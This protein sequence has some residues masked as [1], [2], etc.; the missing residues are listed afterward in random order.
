MDFISHVAD[1]YPDLTRDFADD[2]INLLTQHHAELESELREK[3]VG[4]LVLLRK[5]ELIDSA[6]YVVSS[7]VQSTES[8]IYRLLNTLFPIL[9]VTP[10]K[11]LRTFLYAKIISDLRSSNAKST[12]HKLNR[13][14]QNV[15]FN[16]LTSDRTSPKGIWAIRVTRELWRRQIWSDAK[17]VEIMK[18]AALSEDT[19][20]IIGGVSFFLG[21]DK[22]REEAAD[23]SSDEDDNL[24]MG[25]LK[26]VAGVNKK[27]VKRARDLKAA[28]A[29]VRRKERKK[30]QPH[31]LNFSA[32]HLLNDPQG[33]AE[34]LFSRHLQNK[35]SKLN[36]EQKLAVLQLVTRLVGL[37]KLTIES[38]YSW[39]TDKLNPRQAS[40]TSF[41][42]SFAQATHNL[43]PPEWIE[44]NVQKIANEF[45]SEAAAAQVAA[46]GLNS[47]REICARQPLAMNETLL[48]DLVMYRKSKDKGVVMAA[49][50]LMSLYRDVDATLLKRR[51]RGRD[52]AMALR[53]GERKA[54]RFGEEEA[55]GIEGLDLLQ[56]WKEEERQKKLEAA[57]LDPDAEIDEE[58]EEAEGWKNWDAESDHSDDSGGWINVS[59]DGGD[60]EI[61]DN[62]DE[63]PKS[64]KAKVDTPKKIEDAETPASVADTLT[65][66]PTTE[67][68]PTPA[69][70][71]VA[72]SATA[73]LEAMTAY[74]TTHILTPADLVKLNELRQTAAVTR[75]LPANRR[76]PTDSSSTWHADNPL[77]ASEIE[78]PGLLG[79]KQTKEE[80]IAGAKGDKDEKHQSAT[81]KRK[82]KKVLEGKST[83][84]KEKARKK[85][86]LMTIGKA[87]GKNKRSLKQVG[88]VLRGHIERSKKGGR[89]GNIGQ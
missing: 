68:T 88:K 21:G 41:L 53:T 51:D 56:K 79:H 73:E 17:A 58:A 87:R 81:A 5:K 16:L 82:E 71:A 38:L 72:L 44:S 46:A 31:L 19:K 43:V 50:G 76:K 13:T 80:R 22:E 61:S 24:D 77:T 52:A 15:L 14:V 66:A 7:L 39:F 9:T 30:K 35:K 89:R 54:Q 49:K 23:E 18:E 32:L 33:F 70:D 48:Q 34:I 37:H 27:T 69:P 75:L 64:K 29:A 26:H 60:I 67:A 3:L 36:L 40:V 55:G 63:N 62:E 59:D 42:A 20:V 28:A 6:K 25:K 11:S 8:D 12:N 78:A 1:C 45:V 85:N 47:I 57:G 4:S 65:P 10:S 86:F 83:T 2:L 74:A 84:N